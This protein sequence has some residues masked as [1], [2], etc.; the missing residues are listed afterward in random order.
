MVPVCLFDELLDLVFVYIPIEKISSIHLFQT[1]GLRAP[2][3]RM[4]VSTT[5]IKIFAKASAILVPMAVR[6]SSLEG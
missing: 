2:R 6:M 3:L 4:S 5:A 1:S